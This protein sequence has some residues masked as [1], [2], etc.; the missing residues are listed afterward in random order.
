MRVKT[1]QGIFIAFR[2]FCSSKASVWDVTDEVLEALGMAD[3]FLLKIDLS[4]AV[5][6]F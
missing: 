5:E 4:E 3:L 1:K 2:N 6:F